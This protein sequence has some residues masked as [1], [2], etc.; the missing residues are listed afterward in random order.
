MATTIGQILVNEALPPD[1][2]DETRTLGKSETDDLLASLARAHPELYRD[3]SHK[4]VEL[5]RNAAF[6]EGTTLRLSDI[7]VPVEKQTLLDHVRQQED[8][9][10]ADK[11]MTPEEKQDTLEEVYGDVNDA[12]KKMTYDAAL[13]RENP[14]AL[15]VKSKARGNPDQLSMLLTTP[16]VY[17]DAKDRTIPVFINRSYAE[18]LAPHEYWAAT[19]GARKGVISSK[20]ATRQAGYVGKLFGMAVMDSVVT[21]DDCSTPYGIPVKSDDDDNVGSVLARPAAGFDA[22]TV[23]D[24]SVMAALKAKKVDEISVRSPITCGAKQGVCRHCVGIR[25]GG[26]FPEIGYHI[27]LNAA[28]ALAE[29]IAQSSLNVKHCI[30]YRS[31]ILCADWSVK[32]LKDVRVGD[33]I[34]GCGID[35]HMRPVRVLN[36]FDNGLRECYRTVFKQN[37]I[38]DNREWVLESTLDHKLLSTRRVSNQH[39]ASLNRV[40]RVMPAGTLSKRFYAVLPSSY[41]DSGMVHEPL[42]LLLGNLLGDGCYT[43]A[44]NAVHLSSADAT[45]IA[46]LQAYLEPLGMKLTKLQGHDDYYR[47]SQSDASAPDR[48]G[49]PVRNYLEKHGMWGKYAHE[50][51]LPDV[52]S[53]WDNAS[54]AAL[55]SGLIVTDGSVYASDGNGKPSVSLCSTSRRMLEQVQELLRW[56]FGILTSALTR[57]QCAGPRSGRNFNHDQYQFTITSWPMVQKFAA[58]IPLIGVKALKLKAFVDAFKQV[59]T[60][61][62]GLVRVRQDYIGM[63]PTMDIEVDHPDHLFVL[64]NGLVVSNSG[65]KA[66][67]QST[68]SGFNVIKNLATV[69]QTFPDRATVADHDGTVTKIEEAPQGGYHVFIDDVQHY[70]P[71]DMPVLVKEGD[72]VEAGDQLSDGIVNPADVVRLKGLGEG[73]RYFANRLTQAFRE[74]RFGVNRRNAEVLARSIVNHVQVEDPEADGGNLPGDVVT[75]SSWSQGYR[76]RADAKRLVPKQALGQYLE[77]PALHYTI[78][79]RM[80]K[81]VADTLKRHNIQDV[82]THPNPVGVAPAMLSVV[83][84]PEYT[85]DW[86]AR[87]SSSYLQKRL[88]EDVHSGATSTI[89]GTHPIPGIAKGVE[90]GES[91]G[92]GFTY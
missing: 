12:L 13:A 54:V 43:E 66:K 1:F 11:T 3:I 64:A 29:Q 92:K 48:L 34:M 7:R 23:I 50:K 51:E 88:L 74:T 89:H 65:K 87:L 82:L 76:P 44:V 24:K 67:G 53:T 28:S 15:Q 19:Y 70:V 30:F 27:G 77:E 83:K 5:G 25:E 86:M 21:E 17:Q 69:P 78:G 75:Y 61:F 39:A 90:F 42:A 35:G 72:V 79:T 10:R 9:I 37:G 6:D 81:S 49:N 22:G 16:G 41:D 18:G 91:K 68:Y 84:T 46:D 38:R 14:F 40:P 32:E 55:I 73:R 85:N 56:R 36:V 33:M 80:T 52:V 26:K 58:V 63:L 57:V 2:R 45:Q 62:P 8:R 71:Q 47:V 20:F 4:L 31:N 59:R 60:A